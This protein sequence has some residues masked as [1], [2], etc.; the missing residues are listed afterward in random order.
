MTLDSIQKPLHPPGDVIPY[1]IDENLNYYQRQDKYLIGYA[2]NHR[3]DDSFKNIKNEHI[4]Y[5]N[6]S[7][8]PHLHLVYELIKNKPEIQKILA[9]YFLGSN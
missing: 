9:H 6:P 7:W 4:V 3:P 1:N 2:F 8:S 5:N